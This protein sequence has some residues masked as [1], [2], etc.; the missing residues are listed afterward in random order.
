MKNP[1]FACAVMN[2][3]GKFL[4]EY[5]ERYFLIKY[6]DVYND[7]SQNAATVLIS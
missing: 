3:N 5:T 7:R 6:G 4:L 2:K 1:K